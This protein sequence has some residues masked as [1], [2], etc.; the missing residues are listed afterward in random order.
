MPQ[1]KNIV[2]GVIYRLPNQNVDE[3]LTMT[4]ELL[5][6]ISKE[7]KIYYLMGDLTI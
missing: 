2:A 5:S 1:G 4:N 7:N 3:F 6:K